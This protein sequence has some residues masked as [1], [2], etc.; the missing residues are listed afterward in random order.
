[1][2][3]EHGRRIAAA[4]V[5][6]ATGRR[7]PVSAWIAE[8]GAA[9]P[10]T[11]VHQLGLQYLTRFYRLRDGADYPSTAVPLRDD[12]G[13]LFALAFPGDNATFSVS[14]AC[15][16]DDPL[17]RA[18]ADPNGFER[19]LG[20]IP[21]TRPWLDVGE[22]ISAVHP[23]ARIENRWRRLVDANGT[24]LVGNLILVGDSSIHTNPT[25]GRGISL[26]LAQA[27]HAAETLDTHNDPLHYV[28]DFEQWTQDNLG[29][30]FATQ[31]H[32]DQATV[33]RFQAALRGEPLPEPPPGWGQVFAAMRKLAPTDPE[34]ARALAR[35]WNL[36]ATPTEVMS[37][38]QLIERVRHQESTS[39][40]NSQDV[41]GLDRATF[42]HAVAAT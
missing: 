20:I 40:Q 10:P 18:V 30:W 22:P 41:E 25:F 16:V 14:L 19:A 11:S 2:V 42:E 7:S 13:Y 29:E 26:A 37:D 27:Q 6:D 24:P 28:A 3:T 15:F 12:L 17:R 36:L 21:L 35:V 32:G 5:I 34:V 23:M 4:V 9:D 33:D 39:E 1:V 8:V 31:V 38:P